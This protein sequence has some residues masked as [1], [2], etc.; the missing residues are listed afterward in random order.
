MTSLMKGSRRLHR[1]LRRSGVK[2][3]EKFYS[4]TTATTST[5]LPKSTKQKIS[6]D[7]IVAYEATERLAKNLDELMEDCDFSSHRLW[8]ESLTSNRNI[9]SNLIN[10]IN[11]I[12][13]RVDEANP[14][15]KCP[16]YFTK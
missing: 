7:L 11:G 10:T 14:T 1:P 16:D 3:Y 13:E 12:K 2:D 4:P 9:L 5:P 15:L 6:I 8:R